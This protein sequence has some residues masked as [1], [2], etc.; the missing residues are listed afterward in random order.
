MQFK[1][2][3]IKLNIKSRGLQNDN[4]TTTKL[5]LSAPLNRNAKSKAL[6]FF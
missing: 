5:W 4:V 2:I 3:D 1:I 6:F